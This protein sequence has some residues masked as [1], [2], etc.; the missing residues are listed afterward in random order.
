M[1]NFEEPI[2]EQGR[3]T[4]EENFSKTRRARELYDFKVEEEGKLPQGAKSLHLGGH[5]LP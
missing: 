4:K 1:V 5:V 3:T 2:R